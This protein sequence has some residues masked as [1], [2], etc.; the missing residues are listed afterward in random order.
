MIA[1]SATF[2]ATVVPT[3]SYVSMVGEVNKK[4]RA[5]V[6]LEKRDG[7]PNCKKCGNALAA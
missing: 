6:S 7:F 5:K 1:S 2:M 3:Q 4:A